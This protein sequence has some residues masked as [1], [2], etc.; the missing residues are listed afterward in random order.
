MSVDSG[1]LLPYRL[2]P[3]LLKQLRLFKSMGFSLKGPDPFYE[4]QDGHFM[5]VQRPA[6][7]VSFLMKL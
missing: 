3:P 7:E 2:S 5:R 6:L 1:W 4:Y